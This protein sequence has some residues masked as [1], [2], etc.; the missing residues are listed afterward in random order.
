MRM[1]RLNS[2]F[3]C[4]SPTAP[5]VSGDDQS[6]AVVKLGVSPSRSRLLTGSHLLSS[7]DSTTGPRLQCWDR[8]LTP[9]QLPIYN[10]QPQVRRIGAVVLPQ[11]PFHWE[12]REVLQ[13]YIIR[14]ESAI[15]NM[16]SLYMTF[17]QDQWLWMSWDLH[18]KCWKRVNIIW[19]NCQLWY[20]SFCVSQRKL[21][22]NAPC[23]TLVYSVHNFLYIQNILGFY[24]ILSG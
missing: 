24:K 23:D 9:S 12:R 13:E 8:S 2:R 15:L 18:R 16:Q 3:L 17:T 20:K 7:G 10:L 1:G 21:L 14:R 11:L 22:R 4:P 5:E 19:Q 6:A